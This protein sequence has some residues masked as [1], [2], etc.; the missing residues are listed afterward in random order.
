MAILRE[1]GDM[2]VLWETVDMAIFGRGGMAIFTKA[3][4]WVYYG[5]KG[6]GYIEGKFGLY[7]IVERGT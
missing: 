2:V 4:T 1:T 5:K 7:Y 3:G 6:H